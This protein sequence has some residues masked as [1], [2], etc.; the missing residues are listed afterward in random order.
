[1]GARQFRPIFAAASLRSA[2]STDFISGHQAVVGRAV[3]RARTENRPALIATFDPHPMRYFRPQSPWF[4]L[5]TLEQRERLIVAA[6][7]DAMLVFQFDA[8]FAAVTAP[9]FVTEW[10]VRR[11]RA[12]RRPRRAATPVPRFSRQSAPVGSD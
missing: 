6:G 8:D 10:L 1:M 11:G 9:D 4:R 5:T 7:V 12:A 2:I 3:D